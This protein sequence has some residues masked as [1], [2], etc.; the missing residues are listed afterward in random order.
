MAPAA[1]SPSATGVDGAGNAA[2]DVVAG[3]VSLHV[4]LCVGVAVGYS[5]ALHVVVAEAG[6]VAA[7][8]A[9]GWGPPMTWWYHAE[10]WW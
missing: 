2:V 3:S 5:V 4:V 8:V 7:A 9:S 1:A 10:C 6:D